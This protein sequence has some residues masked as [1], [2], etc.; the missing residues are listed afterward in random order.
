VSE[1]RA[2]V[3]SRCGHVLVAS[4]ADIIKSKAL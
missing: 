2:A 1:V 4:L 3:Y